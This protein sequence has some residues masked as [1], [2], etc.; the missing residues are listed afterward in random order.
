MQ[1]YLPGIGRVLKLLQL[2]F[3][4]MLP[5]IGSSIVVEFIQQ[6]FDTDKTVGAMVLV[7]A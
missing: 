2:Y 7:I 1:T 6:F 4:V 5:G 3:N